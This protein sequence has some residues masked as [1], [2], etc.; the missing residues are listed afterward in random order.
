M[1]S[2]DTFAL[3]MPGVMCRLVELNTEHLILM[4]SD[5]IHC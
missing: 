1:L 5:I 3:F 2:V 4:V